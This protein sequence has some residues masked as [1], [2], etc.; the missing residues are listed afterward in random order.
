[1]SSFAASLLSHAAA[2]LPSRRRK[3]RPAWP[4]PRRG[5]SAPR[6]RLRLEMLEDRTLPS[7]GFGWALHV[8]GPA[9]YDG[10][11]GIATDGQGN[12]YVSGY[13]SGTHLNFDPL[14]PS[15]SPS[16]YLSGSGAFAASYAPSG[17]LRWATP[18][19][20]G[21]G[22]G[23]VA[24]QGSN[25]YV[26]GGGVAQLDA[27]S[28]AVGWTV[29][30]PGVCW[31]VAV[32]PTTGNVYV[33]G[34]NASSQAFVAQVNA[35][36]ALQWTQTTS[37]DSGNVPPI[38][39]GVAVYDAPNSGPE[40]VDV[41]GEYGGTV[42]VGTTTMTTN[43]NSF[44]VWKLNSDGTTAQAK[45]VGHLVGSG[46]YNLCPALTVDGS[47]NPYL[48]GISATNLFVARLDPATLLPSWIS[49]FNY[50]NTT[51]GAEAHAVAV[52]QAGH[53]Y[54][55]GTFSG[56]YDFD[57]GPGKYLLTS[58]KNGKG[59]DVYVAELNATDGSLVAAVDILRNTGTQTS[60]GGG[61][62][63]DNSSPAPAV[64]TTGELGGTA[65]FGTSSL[66]SNGSSDVFV[67][68]LTTPSASPLAAPLTSPASSS[69]PASPS[70]ATGGN[71]A[72]TSVDAT[73]VAALLPKKR[74]SAALLD[75][76]FAGGL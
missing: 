71:S 49:Y 23:G 13:F 25:V 53:V 60:V 63:V 22:G 64:Y 51:G 56:T 70:G 48:T 54:S 72:P 52:D 1:M 31:H 66:T 11:Y 69:V 74:E 8:G 2:L 47:G 6:A 16:A 33:A 18:L 62:A 29:S 68:K 5:R 50:R 73:L 32:G 67:A 38:G 61:I 19:G 58:G 43:N 30:I 10:G 17:A 20:G 9:S 24:V 35:S 39:T 42:T 41:V 37:T 45:D 75:A 57:P 40:S 46:S 4:R 15:P 26:G 59:G 65:T 21:F 55:T 34:R 44:F 12:V 27:A 28:G 36:G 14:N 3:A 76:V 7:F